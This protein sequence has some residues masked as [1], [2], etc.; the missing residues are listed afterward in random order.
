MSGCARMQEKGS[1]MAQRK[2]YSAEF[3]AKVAIEALRE[4]STANE[5]A[6][7]HGVHPGQVAQWKSQALDYLK[8]VFTDQRCQQI[9]EEELLRSQL[10]QEIGQLKVELDFLKK[11]IGSHR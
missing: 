5:I 1:Q 8:I 11:K 9:Q 4:Q 10:Y 7:R 3:K 6:S 2:R